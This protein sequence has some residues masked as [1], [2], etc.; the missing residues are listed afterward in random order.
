[1]S[2]RP[3]VIAGTYSDVVFD[4]HRN[5]IRM[6]VEVPGER[7]DELSR[8]LGWPKPGSELWVAVAPLSFDPYARR[9][10]TLVAPPEDD[11]QRAVTACAIRCTEA[12][13][14]QFLLGRPRPGTQWTEEDAAA[15]VRRRLNISSRREIAT[16]PAAYRGW[17]ALLAQFMESYRA[18][19]PR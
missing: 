8:L 1:M 10:P 15:A 2:D 17:K 19:P 3:R 6:V 18:P 7:G 5:V 13:F 12:S 11:R 14:Q 4:R 16:N 9:A